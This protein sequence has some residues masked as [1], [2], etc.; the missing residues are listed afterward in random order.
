MA[1]YNSVTFIGNIGRDPELQV[2]PE[3]TPVTKFTLAVNERSGR[4]ADAKESTMWLNV[5][6]WRG[7][8]EV[9][10]KYMHKG[11]QVCVSGKLKVRD[12]VDREGAKRTSV[13]VVANE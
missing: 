5:T 11:M 13:D 9:V 4:G 3:G 7:L 2:T 12:Y 8:A 10:E 6:A 1:S